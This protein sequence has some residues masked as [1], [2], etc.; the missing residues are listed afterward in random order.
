MKPADF[1]YV[2]AESIDH[3]LALLAEH[4]D[5]ARILA[6]GQSLMATLNMR[7]SAPEVLIDINGLDELGGIALAEGALRIGALTRHAEVERS[8][9][10]AEHVPLLHQ[11]IGHVAHPAIRNRGTLGGSI[12]FA[13]P[14]AELPACCVALDARLILAGRGGRR[15]VDARA[16]F[17]D[18]YE[19]ALAPGEILEGVE[20]PLAGGDEVCAFREFTRRRG[21]FAIIGLAAAGTRAEVGLRSLSLVFF[22]VAS[23]PVLAAGTASALVGRPIDEAVIKAAAS[24]LD[25]ELDPIGDL[26]ASAAMKRHLA[27]HYLGE[28]ARQ[29]AS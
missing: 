14:A 19:T 23:T 22:G 11:A 15:V 6:G 9:E 26:H 2:R 24:R 8:S 16:F 7:L 21:D 12:A 4:G 25:E 5:A 20:F 27:R 17:R 28:V 1:A 29:L 18:L 3:A 13:D 10:V